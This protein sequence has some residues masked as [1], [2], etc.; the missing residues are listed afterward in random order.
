MGSSATTQPNAA[1]AA[2]DLDANSYQH[3]PYLDAQIRKDG[4]TRLL[5]RRN[6][7]LPVGI[8][9]KKIKKL[10]DLKEGNSI[11]HSQRPY[12]WWPR[13]AAA[14]RPRA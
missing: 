9:S 1:L 6:G 10:A 8:Y 12:Q 5:W 7:Q 14:P 3:K 11:L 2:G 4:L 13:T